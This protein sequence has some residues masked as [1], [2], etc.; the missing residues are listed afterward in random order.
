MAFECIR[1]QVDVIA[2]NGNKAKLEES[3]HTKTACY[4]T[5]STR[6]L[7]WQQNQDAKIMGDQYQFVSSI[8]FPVVTEILIFLQLTLME[9]QVK[10]TQKNLQRRQK[11]KV[12]AVSYP[13]LSGDMPV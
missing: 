9:L 12:I 7:T 10:N 3:P 4:N 6:W 2:G 13:L 1:F 11:T 8:L 5:G